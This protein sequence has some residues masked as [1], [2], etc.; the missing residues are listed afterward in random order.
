[1]TD[2][3]EWV[4]LSFCLLLLPKVCIIYGVSVP[5]S[6]STDGISG[7]ILDKDIVLILFSNSCMKTPSKWLLPKW[8]K[9]FYVKKVLFNKNSIM[10]ICTVIKDH[11]QS[12]YIE[13]WC[14]IGG[15]FIVLFNHQRNYSWTF[16]RNWAFLNLTLA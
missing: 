14:Q 8:L 9:H 12:F 15:I 11:K 3:V 10:V 4:S 6:N 13:Y 1:M 2:W 7:P 16:W 5:S